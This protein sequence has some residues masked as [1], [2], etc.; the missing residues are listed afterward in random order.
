MGNSSTDRNRAPSAHQEKDADAPTLFGDVLCAVDGHEESL[1]AVE[2]AASLTGPDGRVT[3][4]T[5]T[6]YR[7]PGDRGAA[8]GPQRAKEILRSEEHTSELQSLRHLV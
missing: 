3:L 1:E 5:V 6:S 2:Q 4:L 8:I 7:S